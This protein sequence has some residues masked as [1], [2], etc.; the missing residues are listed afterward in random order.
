MQLVRNRAVFTSLSK[1][2][3]ICI[4]A[5]SDWL[6]NI[7]PKFVIQSEVKPRATVIRS[8]TFSRVMCLFRVLIVSMDCLPIE[9]FSLEY[10][11][12][13][14]FASTTQHDWLKKNLA[15]LFHPITGK[16]QTSCNS[17]ALVFPGFASATYRVL[18]GLLY[19][20]CSLQLARVMTLVWFYDSLLN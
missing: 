12:E 19:C 9:R 1:A 2:I 14:G 5:L 8:S 18:I 11:K 16:I 10:R 20:P 13:I 4:S 6:K 17:L 7:A 15:P 3:C